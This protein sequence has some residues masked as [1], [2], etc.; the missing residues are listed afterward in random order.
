VST[1]CIVSI[2]QFFAASFV[3]AL[4]VAALAPVSGIRA[5]ALLAMFFAACGVATAFVDLRRE[6]PH[7]LAVMRYR[8]LQP[9]VWT[10]NALARAHAR[11]MRRAH[12]HVA[13]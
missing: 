6:D 13:P 4:A 2:L 5:M 11:L 7:A 9:W 1:R 10:R 8:L 12:A 3:T